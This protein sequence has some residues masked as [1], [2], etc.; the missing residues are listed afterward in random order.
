[1][2]S[3]KV[4]IKQFMFL[5]VA[6][7]FLSAFTVNNSIN[8]N[9]ADGYSIKFAGTDAEGVFSDLDGNIQFNPEDPE[10]STFSFTVA[11]NSINTGNGMK[12][13]HAVSKKWFDAETYPNITF[14]SK[15]VKQDGAD[16][17]VTG[18]MNIHGTP[19]EMTI[20]FS[21]DGNAFS[22]SFSVNRMDFGVGTMKGMSKKVSNEIKLEVSIP[23][24]NS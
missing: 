8:W 14:E 9:I 24:S 5:T 23:V 7:I 2:K 3:K 13:K 12:N 15:S 20:P 21:F 16:Y 6:V 11:V 1:M 22:S 18:T 19:K 4:N 10:S 17:M